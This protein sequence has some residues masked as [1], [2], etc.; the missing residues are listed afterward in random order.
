MTNRVRLFLSLLAIMASASAFP[1]RADPALPG[2]QIW[3]TEQF[4]MRSDIV[5]R[6]FLIQ[7]GK[8]LL[9]QTVKAPA[10]YVLD[11]IRRSEWSPS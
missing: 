1:T 11:G 10:V 7:V 4:V 3:S 8:P 6:D 5:G 9:P 2:A